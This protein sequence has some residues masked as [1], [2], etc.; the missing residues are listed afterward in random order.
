VLVFR[1]TAETR[2]IFGKRFF[3]NIEHVIGGHD[4]EELPS[5][6]DDREF[7]RVKITEKL[8]HLVLQHSDRQLGRRNV[9]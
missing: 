9:R 8:R 6:V 4:T 1:R 2:E 3:Q 5:R 7:H